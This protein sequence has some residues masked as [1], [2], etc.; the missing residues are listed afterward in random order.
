MKSI[1]IV[2]TNSVVE[3]Y[4]LKGKYRRIVYTTS[5]VN[6]SVDHRACQYVSCRLGSDM[7]IYGELHLVLQFTVA[8]FT[9]LHFYVLYIM[10]LVLPLDLEEM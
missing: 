2:Y 6:Y 5:E 8:Y 1:R 9:G 3:M 7:D 10:L 4:R